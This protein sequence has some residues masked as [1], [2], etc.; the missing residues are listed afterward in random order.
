MTG[1]LPSTD[2][3]WIDPDDA[4][5]LSTPDWVA[6]IEAH[7]VVTRGRPRSASPK[8]S[9]TVRLDRDVVGLF[10]A[11]GPGWQTRLNKALR[12]AMGLP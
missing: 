2:P 4:P 10:K 8:V 5:D 9:V 1:K 6:H 7:G 12:E 3:D 11:G